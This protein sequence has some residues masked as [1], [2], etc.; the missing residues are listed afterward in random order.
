MKLAVLSTLNTG[1]FWSQQGELSRAPEQ[2]GLLPA[3]GSGVHW[4]DA[5]VVL[6]HSHL[7][8][9]PKCT[10]VIDTIVSLW[11]SLANFPGLSL[12]SH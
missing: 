6:G 8:I 5:K 2:P 3:A 7:A 1:I 10:Q 11:L 12:C 9:G 4:K